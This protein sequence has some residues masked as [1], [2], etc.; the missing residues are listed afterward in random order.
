MKTRI[1]SGIIMIALVTLVL[2]AGLCWNPIAITIFLSIL[3]AG[4][5]FEL[6]HNALGVKGIAANTVPCVASASS[7]FAA[8]Y[9]F[10]GL[11]S[12]SR[13]S[14]EIDYNLIFTA[15]LVLLSIGA[16]YVIAQSII[17][18]KQHAD[19]SLA[20]IVG[21]IG[22]P[23]VYAIA[24]SALGSIIADSGRIYYLLLVAN[25]A[26]VCDT[27]AYF[28]GVKLGKHKLCP[29]ISPKKTVEGAIGGIVSSL[30]VTVII[31]CA[32]GFV[33][34][35]PLALLFTVPLCI[36]GMI[37]DLFASSIKRAAGIKD[38]G[39]LIPGH[40]GVLDR[41]D[42]ILMISPLMFILVLLGVFG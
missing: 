19:F 30:I 17:I 27:G 20:K 33:N 6:C 39:D 13:G 26:C 10:S 4:G 35:L 1:I 36:I 22:L 9:W 11:Y 40:G 38:Y 37:G 32:F 28:V 34:K 29:E 2:V 25:F 7:V 15:P 24:F 8:S 5:T 16:V 42:S 23:L 14:T 18:F 3:A 41:V 21:I 12:L 31:V